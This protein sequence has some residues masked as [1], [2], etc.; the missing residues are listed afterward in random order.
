MTRVPE[1]SATE[2]A[3]FNAVVLERAADY[4]ANPLFA[5]SSN[6]AIARLVATYFPADIS[7]RQQLEAF[8]AIQMHQLKRR[9]RADVEAAATHPAK[10]MRVRR[11]YEDGSRTVEQWGALQVGK[12]EKRKADEMAGDEVNGEGANKRQ[13]SAAAAA[14]TMNGQKGQIFGS[15]AKVR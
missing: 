1:K 15:P 7:P 12:I 3:S 9:Y 4:D 6:A 10:K 13:K 2:L 11:D 14:A 8:A 5:Q